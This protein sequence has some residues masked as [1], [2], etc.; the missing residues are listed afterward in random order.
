MLLRPTGEDFQLIGFYLGRVLNVV[1]LAGTVPLAWALLAREWAPAS[2][3]LLMVGVTAL[4]GSAAGYLKPQRDA[5]DWSHGMVVVALIWLIVPVLGS[6]P[7]WLSGHYGSPLDAYFDAM[8]GITTTGLALIQDLDHLPAS[9][10]IWRHLLHFLGGQGIVLAALTFFAGRGVLALYHG[11]ARDE[12]IFPSVA[13][14]ARFIWWVSLFHAAVGVTALWS[15]AVVELGFRP[16]RALLHA[17]TIFMAAF[18]TGGF[19]PQSTSLAYY[20]SALFEIVTGVLMLAGA[21]SFGLH[22]ALWRGPRNVLRN[23]ETRTILTTFLATLVVT[24]IGLNVVGA[25][26]DG[27][28]LARQGFFQLLSAHTGTG[29]STISSLDLARWSALAFVGMT[30]AMALGGMASST[31]GGI[32]A[33]RIGLTVRALG[34]TI[35]EVLLPEHSVISDTYWQSGPKTLTPRLTQ[36]VMAVSLLYVGLYLFGAAVGVAYGYPLG[37]ML[38]ESVS[39]A[40]NV[41]LS[42]GITDPV[43]MPALLKGVF[44]LQM[45]A[46][47]LEFVAGFALMGFFVSWLVGE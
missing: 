7:L 30:T 42:V 10:N 40:A 34:N 43:T 38:F 3:F 27:A 23:L 2:A 37:P 13:S 31:A 5:L 16:D 17:L 45:W 26:T 22:Y 35:K 36:S 1:A 47:R 25:Y 24:I 6:I 46:G 44:I 12:R 8:S 19:S 29:F 9:M 20:H 41:G 18:D 39:A 15:V 4:L 11:E 32:K 33:L 28:S 21:L 14:T